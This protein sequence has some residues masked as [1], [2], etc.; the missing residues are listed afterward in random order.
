ME[1]NKRNSPLKKL[2]SK[3]IAKISSQSNEQNATAAPSVHSENG[4]LSTSS[5]TSNFRQDIETSDLE[6]ALYGIQSSSGLTPIASE[7]LH[8]VASSS[9]LS[10]DERSDS[11]AEQR[12]SKRKKRGKSID[13]RK[14]P[15][16]LSS[17]SSS[18]CTQD[19]QTVFKIKDPMSALGEYSSGN[20]TVNDLTPVLGEHSAKKQKVNNLTPVLGEHSARNQKRKLKKRQRDP[21]K[22]RESTAY[23]G[24]SSDSS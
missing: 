10:D 19:L 4:V 8:S 14:Q 12:K 6:A 13:Y 24:I 11:D 7:L 18:S 22:K 5:S 3:L 9:Y 16:Q 2:K 23:T 21:E 1:T 15:R 17:S 20:Q